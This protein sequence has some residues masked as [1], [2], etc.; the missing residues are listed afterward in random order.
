MSLPDWAPADADETVL[1]E[2]QPRPG[3][4]I[5]AAGFGVIAGIFVGGT[6]AVISRLFVT[7]SLL[8]ATVSV[9]SGGLVAGVL[10][11]VAWLWR[12]SNRYLLTDTTLYHRSGV[13]QLTVVELPVAKIQNTSYTQSVL[14]TIFDH[15][16]VTI[17]TAGSSGAELTLRGL[18]GPQA[19][20]Q[21]IA[22]ATPASIDNDELPGT[23]QQWSAVHAEVRQLREAL[24]P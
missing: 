16:T 10:I 15:G 13:F 21:Q 4:I 11:W 6:A 18:N 9:L 12:Q 7:S 1:W 22:R 14:G 17:D 24:E 3:T 8:L 19:V 2:G 5:P 20:Q 23:V